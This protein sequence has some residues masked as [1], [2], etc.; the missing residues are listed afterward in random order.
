MKYGLITRRPTTISSSRTSR[1][2]LCLLVLVGG[3]SSA[4]ASAQSNSNTPHISEVSFV[5]DTDF[6]DEILQ[7]HI[8]TAAN[9]EFLGLRGAHWWLWLYRIGEAGRLGSRL[10][11]A[12]MNLGEPRTIVDE[13]VLA[14]DLDQLRVF[15]ERE[16]YLQ[17]EISYQIEIDGNHAYITFNIAQG[18][19]TLINHVSYTGLDSLDLTQRQ[20]LVRTS[21]FPP[22][23]NQPLLDYKP[24]SQRFRENQLLEERS[25][26]LT[27]L[28]NM[29]FAAVTRDSIRAIV[30]PVTMDS[31]NV[32]LRIRTGRRFRYGTVQFEV[33]GPESD[34]PVRMDTFFT[35]R[36]TSRLVISKIQGD[37]RIK[38]SL[39]LKALD[40][41]PGTW[42]N[43]SE[44]LATKRHLEATG[45]FAF[46]DIV[47]Q[48][49][50][51]Q[52]LPHQ[53]TV[54]TRPRH[55]FLFSTFIRQS[56][57]A[58]GGVENELGG[59]LG[60][61]YKNANMFGGGEVLSL[62]TTGSIAADIDTTFLSSTL[63]EFSAT[64]S[65]PYLIAPFHHLD[66]DLFQTRT[67][68][69]F[70]YLTARREDL[71]LII[72]GRIA[73]RIRF[74]LQHNPSITSFIDLMDLSLSQPDTLRG[75]ESRFLS[76][77]LGT[78]GR[79]QIIDPVQRAQILEDYT[80]PQ[81]NN[82]IRYTF[83]SE[84]VNLLRRDEGYSYEASIE[85]GG[86]LPYFLDRYIFTPDTL[87][88]S[89]RLFSFMDS[90]SEAYYR[91]YVRFTSS[92]RR[93]YRLSSRTVLATKFFGGWVH[94]IGKAT[95]VPFTHRFYSGGASSVR[96]WGLRQLGPGAAS[97]SQLSNNQRETNLLGG[98]IKLEASLELRQ[99]IIRDR[100]GADW[101]LATFTD[102]GNVWFGSR[103]PGFNEMAPGQPTGRLVFENLLQE[104]GMGW[105]VG[106]RVS[107]AYLVAR[108][109]MAVQVHDPTR[110]DAGLFP[111]GLNDWVGYF[112]LG[113][114]F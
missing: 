47:S 69:T 87:E 30:T 11:R 114:A 52:V 93:Y 27:L 36:D 6:P 99:T 29:G 108:L 25:R 23:P 49:P 100:L 9:R 50:V 73:T 81:I 32:E 83:R 62:S 51:D 8:R 42:Y 53:I 72:R 10:G 98:D 97:F 92:F 75:F 22:L 80:Q 67:R 37:R 60:L 44:I 21:L 43:Q 7:S 5:G 12:L 56:N 45:V 24:V 82:A 4:V 26:L 78:E 28:R 84:Q 104:T 20:Q 77:V 86:M 110:P 41:Q 63:A 3:L 39:L 33:E 35:N 79:S 94:P 107:W 14:T 48:A 109:D 17:T 31:F 66:L 105:G 112:R 95:V 16:G 76:R 13:A 111:S 89:L 18:P 54:R 96:G 85:L 103:N 102:A 1:W 101:I 68:F 61:T 113:H 40:I 15:F 38:S 106:V 19:A 88:Q 59:G 74:E 34:A 55:Q 2:S 46:T 71:S 57:D 91:Q 58:L 90:N 64:V 65:L 70:S